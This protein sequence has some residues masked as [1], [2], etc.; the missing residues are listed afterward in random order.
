MLNKV[1]NKN[2][3][4]YDDNEECSKSKVQRKNRKQEQSLKTKIEV[5]IVGIGKMENSSDR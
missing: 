1:V 3:M 5:L 4:T 2:K